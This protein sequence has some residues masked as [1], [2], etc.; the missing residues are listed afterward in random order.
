MGIDLPGAVSSW[1]MFLARNFFMAIP[2]DLKEAAYIDGADEIRSML[3]IILPLS[4]PI[5]ATLALFYGIGYWN[6]YAPAIIYNT[7]QQYHTLLRGLAMRTLAVFYPRNEYAVMLFACATA[8]N[9]A[10]ADQTIVHF[11]QAHGAAAVGISE[12]FESGE[13]IR[14]AWYQSMKQCGL[15]TQEPEEVPMW[16]ISI[17]N[18]LLRAIKN[19]DAKAARSA[20]DAFLLHLVRRNADIQVVRCAYKRIYDVV[21]RVNGEVPCVF[22]QPEGMHGTMVEL[23]QG[24]ETLCC[25]IMEQ[26]APRE[27]ALSSLSRDVC[28]YIDAN[29]CEDLSIERLVE[30]FHIS[31]SNLRKVFRNETGMT[32]KEYLD[33]QRVSM[34]KR[35]LREQDLQIQQIACQVGFQYSQSFI[36]F[37]RS[38]EGITPSEYRAWEAEE[39]MRADRAGLVREISGMEV[40]PHA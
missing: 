33:R 25:S 34:A 26:M 2:E 28:A 17:E 32:P 4:M 35:M 14:A 13:K 11:L 8:R 3:H 38:K 37:F 15:C 10:E 1:N 7:K 5:I 6:Q 16:E 21:S 23:D 31:A 27:K 9:Q 39:K 36:A 18:D 30:R 20:L 19:Q 40:W 22:T 24:L 29:L 12:P